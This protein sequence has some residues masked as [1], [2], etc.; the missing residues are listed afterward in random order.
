MDIPEEI[1]ERIANDLMKE[2]EETSRKSGK[3]ITFDDIEGKMLEA[4][5]RIGEIM[6]QK[7][8]ETQAKIKIDKKKLPVLRKQSQRQRARTKEN[9]KLIRYVNL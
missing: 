5:H 6:M 2:L 8:I 1:I 4:R 3:Q 9:N 7:S